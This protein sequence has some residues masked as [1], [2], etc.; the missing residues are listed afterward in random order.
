[1]GIVTRGDWL[2][3]QANIKVETTELLFMLEAP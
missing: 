3:K 2:G 1:M